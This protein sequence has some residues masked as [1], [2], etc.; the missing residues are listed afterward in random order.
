MYVYLYIYSLIYIY[1][2]IQVIIAWPKTGFISEYTNNNVDIARHFRFGTSR[3]RSGG[4]VTSS[5]VGGLSLLLNGCPLPK[6]DTILTHSGASSYLSAHSGQEVKS[7]GYGFVT[8]SRLADFD[9][10][11][12]E[13]SFCRNLSAV[14]PSDCTEH[15]WEVIGSGE[16]LFMP[17]SLKCYAV[18]MYDYATSL[19]RDYQHL[20][21][22]RTP[23]F[24][25]FC[26]MGRLT[27]L[28][29]GMWLT[30]LLASL[31]FYHSARRVFALVTF[32]GNGIVN[33]LPDRKSVV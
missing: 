26:V 5:G 23:W 7:N 31:R 11:G 17:F 33:G 24:H 25:S 3:I 6:Q 15:D 28:V 1:T 16:C 9:P 2:C 12:F 8:S 32:M 10:V 21:D 29:T 30:A 18:P 22:L 19:L 13:L 27:W 20:R 14:S 4:T